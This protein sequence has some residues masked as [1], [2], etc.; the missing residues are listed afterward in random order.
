[1]TTSTRR[2]VPARTGAPG[3]EQGREAGERHDTRDEPAGGPSLPVAGERPHGAADEGGQRG[4]GGNAGA[5]VGRPAALRAGRSSGRAGSPDARAT[6]AADRTPHENPVRSRTR[7]P[8]RVPHGRDQVGPGASLGYG[9]G[10]AQP[11][12]TTRVY[13]GG[14]ST[15]H[16][17]RPTPVWSWSPG[18]R[19]ASAPASS[20]RTATGVDGRHQ[21]PFDRAVRG[22]RV[23]TVEGDIS[24]AR[25]DRIIDA[26]VGRFGR[27]DTLVNNAGVFIAKPFTDYTDEDYATV[28]GVNLTGFFD[29]T[30][31]RS[32]RCSRGFAATS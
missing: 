23:V 12:P 26:A 5:A 14:A 11:L 30:S 8:P 13:G 18:A 20:T 7:V 9:A 3:R 31:A 1:M 21:L 25:A 6:G 10:G 29:D 24:E 17:S 32:P 2:R 19:G 28:V 4:H 15:D 22:R 16:G 27:I